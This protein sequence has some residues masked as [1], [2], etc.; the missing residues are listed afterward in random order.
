MLAVSRYIKD[1]SVLRRML[2]ASTYLPDDLP[3]YWQ[4]IVEFGTLRE[5][6]ESIKIDEA[7]VLFQNIKVLKKIVLHLQMIKNFSLS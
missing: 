5:N 1:V 4:V 3:N 7:K 2:F 6:T